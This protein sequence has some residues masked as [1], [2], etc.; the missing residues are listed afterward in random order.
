MIPDKV[1][2]VGKGQNAREADAI[3]VGEKVN[4][5]VI[6]NLGNGLSVFA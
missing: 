4:E 3:R 1:T 2:V 5:I 6:G